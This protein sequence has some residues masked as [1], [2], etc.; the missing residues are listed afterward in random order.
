[1]VEKVQSKNLEEE[2]SAPQSVSMVPF[3]RLTTLRCLLWTVLRSAVPSV[4]R[5][6]KPK[7]LDVLRSEDGLSALSQTCHTAC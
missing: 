4:G 6:E 3:L 2:S 1:M 5:S 7:L